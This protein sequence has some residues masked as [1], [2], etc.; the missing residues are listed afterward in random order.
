M[1]SGFQTLTFGAFFAGLRS[2]NDARVTRRELNALTD[3]E[4][5]D[6]GLIRAD[7]EQVALKGR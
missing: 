2:W 1:F 7:I 6:I 4:L 5:Q 3:R